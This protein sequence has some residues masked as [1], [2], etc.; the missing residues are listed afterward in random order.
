MKTVLILTLLLLVWFFHLHFPSLRSP[1]LRPSLA[2]WMTTPSSFAAC[3]TCMRPRCRRSGWGGLRS[4]SSGRTGCSGMTRA[5]ATSAATPMTTLC[6]CNSKKV[7]DGHISVLIVITSLDPETKMYAEFISHTQIWKLES[8]F[9]FFLVSIRAALFF[10]TEGLSVSNVMPS[11]T[12]LSGQLVTC[13]P[14]S[15][16][17]FCFSCKVSFII[18]RQNSAFCKTLNLAC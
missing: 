10:D 8:T 16:N 18:F 9:F 11:V 2:S 1:D 12:G 17:Y 3:W 7:R 14:Q 15:G 5:A 6:C 4:C 13:L